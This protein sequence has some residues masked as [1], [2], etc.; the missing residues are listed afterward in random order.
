MV[1]RRT[2]TYKE[3]KP[4][5]AFGRMI[6]PLAA[7]M[8]LALLYLSVKLFFFAP[9]EIA[10]NVTN[11][12]TTAET[13]AP[14]HSFEHPA[15][16]I[17]EADAAVVT[18][19]KRTAA[20]TT[21]EKPIQKSQ[22]NDKNDKKEDRV[23]KETPKPA[24]NAGVKT[25]VKVLRVKKEE[26]KSV[27]KKES[28]QKESVQQK[29]PRTTAKNTVQTKEPAKLQE[30]WDVQ[31]GGFAEKAGAELTIKQAKEGGFAAYVV[32]DVRDG[33]PFYKVRV[34]G[35]EDKTEA[36]VTAA[37]LSAAGFPVYIIAVKR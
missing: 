13:P 5:T 16:D 28:A 14:Q 29:I 9:S 34:K 8:A 25:E 21:V 20:T 18:P 23:Q 2:R 30:R 12:A 27:V 22:N 37:R 33:K 1:T 26:S 32:Q 7:I 36:A 4:I 3:R 35:A 15:E 31:I 19:K 6:L 17:D 10:M 24:A 11:E